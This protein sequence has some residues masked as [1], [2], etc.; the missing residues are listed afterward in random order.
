MLNKIREEFFFLILSYVGG[1]KYF[2]N[3]KHVILKICVSFKNA[4]SL[5]VML[6]NLKMQSYA[7]TA[8]RRAP[9]HLRLPGILN[10]PGP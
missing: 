9:K 10:R 5:T 2:M 8:W 4:T 3:F 6:S 7:V 1:K